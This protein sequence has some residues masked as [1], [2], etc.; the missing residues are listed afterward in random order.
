MT[1]NESRYTVNRAIDTHYTEGGSVH[2]RKQTASG[3]IWQP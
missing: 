1:S 2:G 3:D